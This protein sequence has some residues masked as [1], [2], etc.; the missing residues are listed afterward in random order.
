[1]Y[2]ERKLNLLTND[3]QHVQCTLGVH[4]SIIILSIFSLMLTF[5]WAVLSY[6]LSGES[7]WSY[8]I[9]FTIFEQEI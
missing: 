6:L 2:Y 4:R 3:A 7:S 1:M 5:S 8:L 9:Y